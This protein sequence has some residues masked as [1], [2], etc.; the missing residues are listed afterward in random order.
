[1]HLWPLRNL[2]LFFAGVVVLKTWDWNEHVFIKHGMHFTSQACI[3]A[4]KG[5][6]RN[7][8]FVYQQ[9]YEESRQKI[10]E[11]L[12]QCILTVP[13]GMEPAR[14]SL[15][16]AKKGWNFCARAFHLPIL[17]YSYALSKALVRFGRY[18]EKEAIALANEAVASSIYYIF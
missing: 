6:M 1:L 13:R 12:R 10:Q 18:S 5:K 8:T 4:F 2:D 16:A 9:E 14:W 7:G 17:S 15:F 11:R 3:T